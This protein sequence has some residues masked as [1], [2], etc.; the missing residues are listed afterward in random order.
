MGDFTEPKAIVKEP[1]TEIAKQPRTISIPFEVRRQA[2]GAADITETIEKF[3]KKISKIVLG[4]FP[5]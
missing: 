2:K 1:N 5:T 4:T 3:K